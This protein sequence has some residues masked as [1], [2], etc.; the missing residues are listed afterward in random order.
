MVFLWKAFAVY[1]VVMIGTAELQIVYE[2][3]PKLLA[4]AGD[5]ILQIFLLLGVYFIMVYLVIRLATK[6]CIQEK[7][8]NLMSCVHNFHNSPQ[9]EI[10]TGRLVF[11]D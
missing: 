8:E 3:V 5:E 11:P 4:R 2:S 1:I 6:Y 10:T 9:S 7:E